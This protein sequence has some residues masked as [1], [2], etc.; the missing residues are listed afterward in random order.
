[1]SS[2]ATT[3]RSRFAAIWPALWLVALAIVTLRR[4]Y[5]FGATPS[6]LGAFSLFVVFYVI[7]PG[8]LAYRCLRRGDDVWM[9]FAMGC[10]LGGALQALAYVGLKIVGGSQLFPYYPITIVFWWI[11]ARRHKAD[12]AQR[13]PSNR[14]GFTV[15]IALLLVCAIAIQRFNLH[16]VESLRCFPDFD[17]LFH[18]GNVAELRHHFPLLDPRFAGLPLTY[19]FFAYAFG[20]GANQVTGIP[21]MDLVGCYVPP[22]MVVLLALQVFNAGRRFS[23]SAWAGLCACA[24]VMLQADFGYAPPEFRTAFNN[25]LNLGIYGSVTTCPGFILLAAIAIELHRWLE[26][27]R[28]V[29]LGAVMLLAVLGSTAS[30]VK[31]SVMP[32]VLAGLAAA[33]GLAL[34]RRSPSAKRTAIALATLALASLPM[35][36]YLSL[37]PENY[38]SSMFH[39]APALA[40]K[41]S[42]SFAWI[43]ERLGFSSNAAPA[44]LAFAM[45]PVWVVGYFGLIGLCVWCLRAQIRSAWK[46]PKEH[47]VFLLGIGA[48]GLALGWSLGAPGLSQLFFTENSQL[49]LAI[50]AGGA[51]ALAAVPRSARGVL[52]TLVVIVF[53]VPLALG[54]ARDVALQIARDSRAD[55]PPHRATKAALETIVW[56][57]EHTPTDAVI[58]RRKPYA[59]LSV[60][61][62]RRTYY[63]SEVATPQH[64]E[65]G[66]KQSN[67]SPYVIHDPSPIG[68]ERDRIQ[69]AFFD[70]PSPETLREIRAALPQDAPVYMLYDAFEARV[71]A[72]RQVFIAAQP[73][74]ERACPAPSSFLA[75]EYQSKTARV[76][77]VIDPPRSN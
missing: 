35:T 43:A 17:L 53:S 19:H 9:T 69:R 13:V 4:P 54:T 21:V 26:L 16:P 38:A 31:G 7:V 25:L 41:T 2:D 11:A 28:R 46:E 14:V 3:P 42:L 22:A 37:G 39:F 33:L 56:L 71:N 60:F 64:H 63:E 24:L 15:A 50:L 67:G 66:W 34:W 47:H 49:A 30:G 58:L 65:W 48:S 36:L 73:L 68:I 77:R 20:A 70:R 62:E 23:S 10:T 18:A 75:L 76:Y 29:T 27:E 45:T 32:V 8:V 51:S 61:A 57:R 5:V 74:D 44:W 72:R 59:L 55:E 12:D 1:M 52:L 6:T 40:V